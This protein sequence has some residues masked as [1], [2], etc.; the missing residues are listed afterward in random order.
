MN[1]GFVS[2]FIP[3]VVIIL[4]M[5]TKKIISSLI[6]GIL[7]GGILLAR[8]NV[9]E[10]CIVAVEHLIKSVANEESAYIIMF[11]F[12][13]GSFGEIMKL[14]GGIKGFSEVANKYIKTEKGALGSVWL[15]SI[16][17]FIDCCF[18]AI[19]TGTIGKALIEK[20]KGSKEKLAIVVNVT[21]CLLIILIPFGTTY[22]GYI[23][24]VINSA[25]N[26]SNIQESAYSL[27]IKSIPFNFYAIIMI[28]LSIGI[29]LFNLK[30]NQV[31]DKF[32]NTKEMITS[33]GHGNEAHEQCE[34]EE[35]APPR[36]FNLIF[37]LAFLII[38]TFFFFW[39]TGQ[40]KASGFL[41]AIMNAEFEKSILL[42]G[43]VSIVVTSI[44]Y[45]FQ[46]IPMEEIE[47][48]FLSGGNEMMPPII[49][50]VLSWGLSSIIED[51]GFVSFITNTIGPG[52]PVILIPVV[53][54]LIGC[55]ASYFMGSAWGTWALLMP[56]AVPLAV[57]TEISLPLAVGAVL[58]GGS[59]GDNAS[60]LGETAILSSTIAEVPLMKHV[61]T[62]LP[63]SIISIIISSILFLLLAYI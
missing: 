45:L 1:Q 20:T 36:P 23:V 61:K 16:F 11:L 25:L 39:Y 35:K 54:F 12:V 38:T 13:F 57:T 21:S 29:I 10:G 27:Y 50:L 17:T 7:T 53:I 5:T 34:F 31:V 37:P 8:G 48:H 62:I 47:S 46:K 43:T 28:L 14:S 51:L 26:K 44:F 49:V 52:V 63:Y 9:I 40:G 6:I 41:G 22:V 24:G 59:L 3:I 55:A 18:H 15:V 42:S 4:A 30:F 19:S 60:P 33:G 56:I 2:L 58:A 32:K